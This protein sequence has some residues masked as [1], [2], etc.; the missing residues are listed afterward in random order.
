MGKLKTRM[1]D[2]SKDTKSAY[3]KAKAKIMNRY[4]ALYMAHYEIPEVDHIASEYVLQKFW[5]EGTVAAYKMPITN[6]LAFSGYAPYGNLAQY[7]VYRKY[8]LVNEFGL[9]EQ[10]VPTSIFTRDKNIAICYANTSHLPISKIV[11]EQVD[12]ILNVRIAID[13]NL[14]INKL[15]FILKTSINNKTRLEKEVEKVLSGA[16]S[17]AVNADDYSS[18]STPDKLQSNFIVDKLRAYE[19][20]L[21]N[22]LLTYLGINNMGMSEK[23]ERA[24]TDEVKSN[25]EL[26]ARYN[27]TFKMSLNNTIKDIK[28]ALGITISFIDPTQEEIDEKEKEEAENGKQTTS[29]LQPK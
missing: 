23:K 26:I 6:E 18:I 13:N 17:I 2:K 8:T 24:I 9:S 16:K 27:G 28:K 22:D 3:R 14:D 25:N 21:E 15:A 12:R 7:G 4:Y 11:S 20:D 1:V 19:K 5:S 10:I 29:N